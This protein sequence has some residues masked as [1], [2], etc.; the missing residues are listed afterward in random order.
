MP[1]DGDTRIAPGEDRERVDGWGGDSGGDTLKRV[2]I[3]E[4]CE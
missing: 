1:G 4:A 3:R 2:L